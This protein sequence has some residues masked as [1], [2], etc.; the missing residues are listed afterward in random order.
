MKVADDKLKTV[1][2]VPFKTLYVG[3]VF[4]IVQ[5]TV[6]VF[7]YMRIPVLTGASQINRV[8]LAVG[9]VIFVRG[10]DNVVLAPN[11]T[12]NLNKHL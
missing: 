1:S 2:W 9:D 11:V 12:L 3:D 5:Q 10:S 8:S 4:R 6:G 7:N